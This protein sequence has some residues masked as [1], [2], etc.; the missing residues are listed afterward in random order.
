[1]KETFASSKDSCGVQRC[2]LVGGSRNMYSRFTDQPMGPLRMKIRQLEKMG[3]QNI[4]LISW[5]EFLN[6]NQRNRLALLKSKMCEVIKRK[7]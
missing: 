1:M 3:Y 5:N 6:V 7:N 4:I 2:V